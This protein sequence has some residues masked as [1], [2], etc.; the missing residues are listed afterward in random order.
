[1][2]KDLFNAILRIKIKIALHFY[3]S[4]IKVYGKNN[5]PKNKAILLVANHQNAL[6]D[7][8]LVATHTRLKPYF[9][10][11]ASVFNKSFIAKLLDFI[12]M[13]PI[14]R[15]RDGIGNMEKNKETFEK[16]TEVLFKKGTIVIFGEG[17]HNIHRNMRPLKKGFARIA[18]QALEANPD[19]DL[20][21]LPV[22]LNYGNHQRTGSKVSIFF[23][24]TIDPKVFYPQFDPLIKAVEEALEP[25]VSHIPEENYDQI[26]EEL[27][28]NRIDLTEPENVR[29][30]LS[31]HSNSPDPKPYSPPYFT[32]KVMKVFHFPIYW[33]WLLI[34]PKIEDPAFIATFKFVIGLVAVPLWYIFILIGLPLLG[35]E[36]WAFSWAF[37][38]LVY[39]LANRNG[40]G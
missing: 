39:L 9:L 19:L 15:V 25:L 31:G 17:N 2:M 35:F 16:S 33:I 6:V 5:I 37:L 21:I 23:G 36:T 18:Y 8:L 38:G 30:F 34:A 20:V 26:Q 11:R 29:S 22:G 28:L 3:F 13:I 10:T 1:M 7:P 27:I 40:Q 12:R 4:K 24:P 32:N 14:Y